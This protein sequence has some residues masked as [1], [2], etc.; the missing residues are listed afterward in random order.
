[1]PP[2]LAARDFAVRLVAGVLLDGHPL[3]QL[4]SD[5]VAR[6]HVAALEARDRGLA[7]MVAATVLRRQGSLEHVL[8]TFLEKPLPA[9]SGRLAAILLAGAAQ[10]VCLDVP[11]HAV[12]DTSVE[13]TRRD[14]RS[15]R[16][17]KLVNAVLRRVSERGKA[18]LADQD[19]VRLDT[20]AWLWQRWVGTYGEATARQ[21]AEA[22]LQEAALDLTIK[23]DAL[24]WAEK[25]GGKLLPTGSVRLA[26]HGR[27]EDLPGFTEGAWWVQDAAAA[28]VARLADDVAGRSVADLCAAPGGKAAQLAAAG[29]KVT[30]VDVAPARLARLRE[31]L[32]R[33]RLEAEV[34]QADAATWSPGRSF[35]VVLLDA[36]C[37]AT[38]TIRRHPDIIR[39]KKA[40][41]VA[42][43]A[44]LQRTILANAAGLVSAGGTLIYATCSLEPEEGEQQI[45]TLLAARAD[46]VLAPIA[47]GEHGIRPEWVTPAGMLR[48]LPFHHPGAPAPPAGMDGFFAARLR[49]IG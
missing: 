12:V 47:A 19:C 41:D 22:N 46:F 14:R 13:L 24:P 27:I 1:M 49:R 43:M 18:L 3:D 8:K 42:R 2:G 6:P 20:P 35:D 26:V 39:L 45:A 17:A 33:V 21:I 31:N 9:D 11:P 7:R 40:E 10:L 16:F 36:P 30:A 29:A 15:H 48:T 25:L 38:G 4:W 23:A 32:A 34:V 5:L 28:L 44:G 37:T